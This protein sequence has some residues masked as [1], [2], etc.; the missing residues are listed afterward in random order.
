MRF[1]LLLYVAI[2][3]CYVQSILL[4]CIISFMCFVS[5]FCFV[6]LRSSVHNRLPLSSA[7]SNFRLSLCVWMLFHLQPSCVQ[8]EFVIHIYLGIDSCIFLILLVHSCLILCPFSPSLHCLSIHTMAHLW[9]L[10]SLFPLICF[11][12]SVI[13]LLLACLLHHHSNIV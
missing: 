3:G 1:Y 2:L 9:S 13:P 7:F 12:H 4:N 11:L 6:F 8:Y 10:F 5:L